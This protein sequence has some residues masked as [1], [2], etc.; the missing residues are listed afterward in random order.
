MVAQAAVMDVRNNGHQVSSDDPFEESWDGTQ[1]IVVE[2]LLDSLPIVKFLRNI[3]NG[4]SG[5]NYRSRNHSIKLCVANNGS[6]WMYIIM[7]SNAVCAS[8]TLHL[9]VVIQGIRVECQLV[10]G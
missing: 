8:P 9:P 3:Q 6:K 1:D 7:L 2:P 4:G 5:C 10:S